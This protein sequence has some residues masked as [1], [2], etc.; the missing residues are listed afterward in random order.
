MRDQSRDARTYEL[1]TI[2]H[3][4]VPEEEI[5]GALDRISG[6][7][8]GAGGAI[9]ET[10]RDSPWGRRRLAYPVRHGGRDLRDGFYTVFHF[11]MAPHRVEEMERELKLNTQVIRYLITTYTPKPLDPRAVEEAEIAAEDAAAEAYAAA[12]AEASRLAAETETAPATEEAVTPLAERN[13]VG[14]DQPIEG[15][16]GAAG[17]PAAESGEESAGEPSAG[18]ET[19]EREADAD[20]S[21]EEA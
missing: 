15:A 10:L 2:L 5:S 7:V 20:E 19:A 14:P 17:Q 1:M 12:Q 18:V 13:G 8:A 11:D 21:T 16:A 6:H 9:Q 4:E 3:P